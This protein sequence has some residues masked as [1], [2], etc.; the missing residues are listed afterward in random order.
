MPTYSIPQA[1]VVVAL[2]A[3]ALERHLQPGQSLQLPLDGV[4]SW[5]VSW[6]RA[7][8]SQE[9]DVFDIVQSGQPRG[10]RQ[11]GPRGHASLVGGAGLAQVVWLRSL[12]LEA[13]ESLLP[14]LFAAPVGSGLDR[15][16]GLTESGHCV[17]PLE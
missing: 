16:L 8:A 7:E 9:T 13:R 4:S 11:L 3:A 2:A 10:E 5:E 12:L 14:P 1:G 17:L 15:E 6:H